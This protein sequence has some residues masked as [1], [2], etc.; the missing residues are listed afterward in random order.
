MR[1]LALVNAFGDGVSGVDV[2]ARTYCS[3]LRKDGLDIIVSS[4]TR[5]Q[6]R[7]WMKANGVPVYYVGTR[8]ERRSWSN[9]PYQAYAYFKKVEDTV[10]EVKSLK[11]EPNLIWLHYGTVDCLN[12]G[13]KAFPEVPKIVHVHGVWTRDF[14]EQ[15]VKQFRLLGNLSVK[16][17][18][19]LEKVYL[20]RADKIIVYSEWMKML[21]ENKVG[22]GKLMYTV[23]N[24]VDRE[25]FD[26]TV[27]SMSRE[28]FG[29]RDED[30][31]VGYVGKFT[32]L[33]GTEYILKAAN[34][35]KSHKF[36]LVGR[37][38]AMPTGHYQTG[39]PSNVI[40]HPPISHELV[41]SFMKM[42]DVYIQPTLRDGV[43]IPIAEALA[44]NK[45]VVTS[46]HPERRLL[47]EDS[48]YYCRPRNAEDLAEKIIE[49][50]KKGILSGSDQIVAKF[51][52]EKNIRE[53]K[54]ILR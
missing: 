38:V 52:V 14:V 26:P 8:V 12:V 6:K 3:R 5:T 28:D 46:D 35:L 4:R 42:I 30:M 15:F 53:L 20:K 39:A 34:I 22:K 51:D 21:V 18:E 44:M 31:V 48:V 32:P 17:L 49:A 54:A 45:P 1:I 37:E 10:S 29:L 33:K 27:Y 23:Y 43:E 2:V 36:V 16:P 7:G 19:Y 50:D 9:I 25:L 11:L 24:P 40:F 41:P 47:Y 13:F